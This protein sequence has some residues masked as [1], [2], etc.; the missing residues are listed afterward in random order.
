MAAE[1]MTCPNCESPK[2]AT[3]K[4]PKPVPHG[5]PP[6][7]QTAFRCLACDTQWVDRDEWLTKNAGA[8]D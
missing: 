4:V 3:V 8:R 7:T 5:Q 1:G 2:V 6:A